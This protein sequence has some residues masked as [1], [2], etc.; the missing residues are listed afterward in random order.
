MLD[1]NP[2]K[3]LLV[4]NYP[5][6]FPKSGEIPII[7]CKIR[8]FFLWYFPSKIWIFSSQIHSLTW[9]L[10]LW[11]IS[12]LEHHSHG[13]QAK[14]KTSF[15]TFSSPNPA[16]LPTQDSTLSS[17]LEKILEKISWFSTNFPHCCKRSSLRWHLL[18]G[19]IPPDPFFQARG[20]SRKKENSKH[21]GWV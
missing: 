9:K 8:F 18:P 10:S 4:H 21:P 6:W 11:N 3:S 20:N 7:F 15:P 13:I 2:L 14:D 17:D 1:F 19:H 16:T 12:H 5:P